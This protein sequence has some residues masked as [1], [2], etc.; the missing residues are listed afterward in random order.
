[1]KAEIASVKGGPRGIGLSIAKTRAQVTVAGRDPAHGKEGL[2]SLLAV[3]P[4]DLLRV[5][6]S[7]PDG[8]QAVGRAQ[9]AGQEGARHRSWTPPPPG[10]RRNWRRAATRSKRLR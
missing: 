5:E 4:R 8:E 3:D 2:A 9:P 6:M 7:K 1:M 10:C